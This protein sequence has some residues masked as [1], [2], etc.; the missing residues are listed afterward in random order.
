MS[1]ATVEQQMSAL[2]RAQHVRT[3]RGSLKREIRLGT[4]RVDDVVT[5]VPYE[6]RTMTVLE[7]LRCQRGWGRVKARKVLGQIGV[8]ELRT[9]ERLS[10]AEREALI[11]AVASR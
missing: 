9:I 2:A 7:L 10:H 11:E 8:P 3:A 4:L 1:P 6:A 5:I